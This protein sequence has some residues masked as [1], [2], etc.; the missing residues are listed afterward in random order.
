[1]VLFISGFLPDPPGY[2]W[3][4]YLCVQ[5]QFSGL[6]GGSV[7]KTF[8]ISEESV[9]STLLYSNGTIDIVLLFW[10]LVVGGR[11][12]P[13]R[14]HAVFFVHVNSTNGTAFSTLQLVLQFDC[15]VAVGRA[16]MTCSRAISQAPSVCE[17]VLPM[18]VLISI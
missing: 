9:P 3:M 1:M 12:N 6:F 10:H 4:F 7:L 2:F 13:Y 17:C 8:A 5:S 18:I 11:S 16:T 14:Y 15:L